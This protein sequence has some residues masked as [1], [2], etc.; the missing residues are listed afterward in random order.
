MA[1]SLIEARGLAVRHDAKAVS[2]RHE[3]LPCLPLSLKSCSPLDAATPS[4]R[5]GSSSGSAYPLQEDRIQ[6]GRPARNIVSCAITDEIAAANIDPPIRG[7]PMNQ[8]WFGL[9]TVAA[10]IPSMRTKTLTKGRE[11]I[12]RPGRERECLDDPLMLR[13]RTIAIP[14]RTASAPCV[15]SWQQSS[16]DD[17]AI[18]CA[19]RACDCLLRHRA[20]RLRVG[21]PD[22]DVADRHA[23]AGGVG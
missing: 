11:S 16:G 23:G 10:G 1:V 5:G 22:H 3:S 6:S 21:R 14:R 9:A 15:R 2:G 12:G 7:A 17:H 20:D 4:R 18:A 8:P 19:S 13:A